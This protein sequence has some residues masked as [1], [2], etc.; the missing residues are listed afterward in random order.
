MEYELII[1]NV[2]CAN[3]IEPLRKIVD[4]IDN[5]EFISFDLLDNVLTIEVNENATLDDVIAALKKNG[6]KVKNA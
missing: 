2:D 3:C 1:K 6:Y 5:V 4:K